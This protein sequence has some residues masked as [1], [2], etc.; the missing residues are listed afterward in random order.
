MLPIR[1]A[2]ICINSVRQEPGLWIYF[3]KIDSMA[4]NT[5]N[6]YEQWD[7]I[8]LFACALIILRTGL[9]VVWKH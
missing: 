2:S 4:L 7:Q 5:D 1:C 8:G 3:H 6:A 9:S